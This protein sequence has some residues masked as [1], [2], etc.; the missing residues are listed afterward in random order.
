MTCRVMKRVWAIELMVILSVLSSHEF[1]RAQKTRHAVRPNPVGRYVHAIQK[2]DF[3][4]VI[5]LTYAYQEEVA[6]IKAQ[7]PQVLWPKLIGEYYRGKEAGFSQQ[8]G[9]WQNYG[10]A[11]GAAMGDPTQAIRAL[12][13]LLPASSRWRITESRTDFVQD[14]IAFGPYE[15]TRVYVTVNY[16]I[17]DAPLVGQKLLKTA[18]LEFTV[19]TKNGLIMAAARVQQGDEYWTGSV[20]LRTA[21]AR[22]YLALSQWNQAISQLEP[23]ESRNSLALEGKDILASAYY[24]RELH[25][26][27][28]MVA[29]P[30]AAGYPRFPQLSTSPKCLSDIGAAVRLNPGL[31]Q[32]WANVLLSAA[33][34]SLQ[35]QALDSASSEV[36]AAGPYLAGEQNS[37]SLANGLRLDIARQY[38][39]WA[40]YNFAHQANGDSVFVRSDV[41]KAQELVPAVLQSRTSLEVCEAG[42]EEASV[43]KR[44]GDAFAEGYFFG[45]LHFMS[46]FGIPLPAEDV[47]VFTKWA[48]Q[49][50]SPAR[51]QTEVEALASGRSVAAGGATNGGTRWP[52]QRSAQSLGQAGSAACTD[53]DSCLRAGNALLQR[54]RNQDAYAAWDRALGFGGSLTFDVWHE[55]TMHVERGTFTLGPSE[56]AFI[57]N[58]GKKA[59]AVVPKEVEPLETGRMVNHAFFRLRIRGKNYNFDFVPLG[60]PC[61]VLLLDQC[62][63]QGIGQQLA[64]GHYIIR[65]IPKLASGALAT[66]AAT[67]TARPAAAPSASTKATSTSASTASCAGAADLGYSIQIGSQRYRARSAASSGSGQIPVFFE[68]TAL[69]VHDPSTAHR[70]AVGAWSREN[71]VVSPA[72]RSELKN[73]KRIINGMIG[74][75]LA[76]LRYQAVQDLLARSMAEA[77]EAAVTGG[78]SLPKAVPHLFW[79]TVD[80]QLLNSPR[81]ILLLSAGIGLRKSLDNYNQIEAVLAQADPA[82]MDITQLENVKA[83]YDKAQVLD[84]PNEAVLSALMP[85]SGLELTSQALKSMVSEVI[86]G[87]PN[88]N[89]R[90]TLGGLWKLQTS[91]AEAGKGFP[92]LQKYSENLNLVL[93]LTAANNRKIDSWAKQ[94]VQLCGG[95]PGSQAS[96]SFEEF[97][98]RFREAVNRRDGAALRGLMSQK[99]QWALDGYV[100][101]DQALANITSIIGWD[102]FWQSVQ[103]AVASAARPCQQPYCE[104]RPGYHASA[105]SP[106]PLEVLFEQDSS[107]KWWWTAVLGD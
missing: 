90:V 94:A 42:L 88:A 105:L 63:F 10:E 43:L 27:I 25:E 22:R 81:T 1:I 53:V 61:Q 70:L 86:P 16:P 92:A 41:H 82:A 12:E 79:K 6:R 19:K 5:D 68:A 7:N 78:A 72:T 23:L 66:S 48:D 67:Q 47:A 83:L 52:G 8:A 80:E 39:H 64:V 98:A 49:T 45:T 71:I 59:F 36:K 46:R 2:R 95:P 14:S 76:I 60:V 85:K 51:W 73:K 56:L 77:A 4:T 69:P 106:F 37:E 84:L 21:M 40:L 26:C 89:E 58:R 87:L 103:K 30:N 28:G 62:P 31:G 50:N 99:F 54:G 96:N 17:R 20:S 29:N 15:R 75:S 101:R 65:T 34:T 93:N 44:K 97:Y 32:K 55:L 74:T 38:L 33:K 91:L 57:S 18:I 102:K 9:F 107:G 35:A 3:K 104:G 24:Q 11:L 100:T 13:S